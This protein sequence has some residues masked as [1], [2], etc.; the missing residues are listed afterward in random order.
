MRSSP[1]PPITN[2]QSGILTF[3]DLSSESLYETY[4]IQCQIDRAGLHSS[5]RILLAERMGG[6]YSKISPCTSNVVVPVSGGKSESRF[7]PS[8]PTTKK[9]CEWFVCMLLDAKAASQPITSQ[10]PETIRLDVKDQESFSYSLP[11]IFSA[12]R[13][14]G[15]VIGPLCSVA[16]KAASCSYIYH[17][18]N[19]PFLC[20][21]TM[22][23]IGH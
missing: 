11:G 19:T 10:P 21:W 3:E 20:G 16:H 23:N 15:L 22:L 18:P 4:A 6:E 8:L 7:L 17:Q 9:G 1:T 14:H 5:F 2:A 12:S 13:H